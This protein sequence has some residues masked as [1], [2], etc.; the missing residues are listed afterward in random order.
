VANGLAGRAGEPEGCDWRPFG[1]VVLRRGPYLALMSTM[2][3]RGSIL[4]YGA[5]AAGPADRLTAGARS[6]KKHHRIG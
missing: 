3:T 2:T 4:R 5:Y 1:L 6:S